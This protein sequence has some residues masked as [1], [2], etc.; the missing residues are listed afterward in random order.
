MVVHALL[1]LAFVIPCAL[2]AEPEVSLPRIA[3]F[4]PAGLKSDSTLA[5]V[6][7]TVAD[8]VE[9]SLVCLQ[10]YEVKRLAPADP[11]REL[12]K[13]RAYC[14]GNRIDQAICGSGSARKGGGYLFRLAVYDRR[15][16]RITIS[17]EGASTGALD[18]FD[19]T[20]TLVAALL[21]GLSG[22]HL[23]FG[24]LAVQTEPPGAVVSVNGK[25]VGQAPVAL[26]GLPV[27]AVKISARSE[28]RE[29]AESSVTIADGET[30]D[31]TLTLARSTGKLAVEMPDD[32]VVKV[33]NSEIGEK[34][35]SGP[36]TEELPTGQYEMV[37]SCPGLEPVSG[38]MLIQRNDTRAWMPWTNAY[39]TVE[40][41]PAGASVFVDG[42]ERGSSPALL[43]VEPG[44]THHV[45]LR[46][47]K[48]QDWSAE[49]ECSPG[50]KQN[51]TA[52]LSP[53]PGSLMVETNL[54]GASIQ[55]D[56][57]EYADSPHLFEAVPAGMHTIKIDDVLQ[58]HRYYTSDGAVTVEVKP[59]ERSVLSVSLKP[60]KAKMIIAGA[61]KGST[62]TV[63]GASIDAE[64]A[65]AAGVDI[66]AGS[67]NIEVISAS[68]QK[69]KTYWTVQ[70][71]GTRTLDC[72]NMIACLPHRTIKIDGKT[73]DWA[74]ILPVMSPISSFDTFP[75]QPGTQITQVYA[76]RDESTLF[77]RID[78]SDGNPM[79]SLSKDIDAQLKYIVQVFVKGNN[80][81]NLD[82]GFDRRSGQWTA[83]T[84][85]NETTRTWKPLMMPLFRN[86]G[87]RTGNG[88]LEI[89]V[90][91]AP[92]A[93]WVSDVACATSFCV[94]SA[95]TEG[96]WKK[97]TTSGSRLIYF[98]P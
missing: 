3:L 2:F 43:Q 36:G 97:S 37:A 4:E 44:K 77:F 34:T 53:M 29:D 10:R 78:F 18:M 12:Q 68:Q 90:P 62:I 5:A 21:D 46:R 70:S 69:W 72:K 88:T 48:Y 65:S 19:V 8:S 38:R 84:I 59:G 81:I 86:I 30:A 15:S 82:M 56:E 14:E 33:R 76:C 64:K 94:A 89:E 75:N 11:S 93:S 55:I 83:L 67:L 80:I 95:D 45:V 25:D 7:S 96:Q 13:I 54:P 17:R 92:Y 20:D 28:G 6:L 1:T 42:T 39:L 73:D 22:T 40:S 60:G 63:D 23:L 61:P 87:Y 57:G 51:V 52:K 85:W 9:L 71:G 41:E 79:G 32:A 26:R 35:I 27:G 50:R 74:G 16:D 31:A 47:E 91:F 58:D 66:P 24:S 49:P 98:V